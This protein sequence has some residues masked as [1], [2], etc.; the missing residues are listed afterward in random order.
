M[1]FA[2]GDIDRIIFR[3]R[4]S[5]KVTDDRQSRTSAGCKSF[6]HSCRTGN[7]VAGAVDTIP[8]CDTVFTDSQT[9]VAVDRNTFR[10]AGFLTDGGDNGIGFD[11]KIAACFRNR[12]PSSGRIRFT[13]GH[14]LTGQYQFA[15]AFFQLDRRGKEPEVDTLFLRFM[16]LNF[17]SGHFRFGTAVDASYIR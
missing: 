11:L 5:E 17:F 14:F 8:G 1:P 4:C 3:N 7:A 12:F 9:A 13:E 16:D 10:N 2:A 15:V 6:D